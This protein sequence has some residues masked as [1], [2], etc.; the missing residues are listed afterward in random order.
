MEQL[1]TIEEIARALRVKPA[2]VYA[3]TSRRKIPFIKLSG[4]GVRFREDKI[5]RWLEESSSMPGDRHIPT[6]KHAHRRS[7]CR[8]SITSDTVDEIVNKAKKEVLNR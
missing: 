8:G 6:G 2:T 1:L 4:G 7:E 3:W 5:L